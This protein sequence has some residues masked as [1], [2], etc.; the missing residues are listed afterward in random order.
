VIA[1]VVVLPKGVKNA[2]HVFV[3]AEFRPEEGAKVPYLT[4]FAKPKALNLSPAPISLKTEY[5]D[6]S[7]TIRLS[8]KM[9][10]KG[11]FIEETHGYHV[12]Y[13]DN[14]FDLKPNEEVTVRVEY[15][16]VEKK[17]D[18]RVRAVK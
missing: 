10:K 17:P 2:G 13:S 14:Y 18:F 4:Y 9:L 7:A 1:A 3:E 8:A 16:S 5:G 15:P 6:H 11:V 12:R